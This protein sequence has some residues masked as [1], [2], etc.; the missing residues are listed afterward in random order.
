MTIRM[1]HTTNSILP[2]SGALL[3][4]RVSGFLTRI[5]IIGHLIV[6]AKRAIMVSRSKIIQ[7]LQAYL[8]FTE[9]KYTRV[10]VDIALFRYVLTKKVREEC[11]C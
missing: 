10:R 9:R 4:F 11:T 8:V 3:I 7:L 2:K 6:S 5:A 1:V